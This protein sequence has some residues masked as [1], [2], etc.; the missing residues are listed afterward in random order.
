MSNEAASAAHLIDA[1]RFGHWNVAEPFRANLAEWPDAGFAA[2]YASEQAGNPL[3]AGLV[4]AGAGNME[5]KEVRFGILGSTLW[6]AATTAASN[7]SVNAMHDSFTPLG[8]LVAMLNIQLGEV[9]FGG[10]GVGLTGMLLFVILAVFL[11]GLMVGRTPELLGKTIGRREITYAALASIV[12]PTLVLTGTALFPTQALSSI[13]LFGFVPVLS[14]AAIFTR[15]LYKRNGNVWTAAF[16]NALLM[17]LV[18][19]ANTAVYFQR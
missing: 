16:L 14:I 11:A 7:G 17:T 3:Q 10:V 4:E 6:A 8:G 19:V 2:L 1:L 9:V 13:L 15:A 5:G 18:T 12:T